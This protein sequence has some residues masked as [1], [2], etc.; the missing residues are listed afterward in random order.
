MRYRLS[1]TD[2]SLLSALVLSPAVVEDA[3]TRS[4]SA[5]QSKVTPPISASLTGTRANRRGNSSTSIQP[6]SSLFLRLFASVTLSIPSTPLVPREDRQDVQE[7][8]QECTHELSI[9]TETV[10]SV[11]RGAFRLTRSL[12]LSQRS[13]SISSSLSA[14]PSHSR[15]TRHQPDQEQCSPD[16]G[17]QM[18]KQ[19][20]V[21]NGEDPPGHWCGC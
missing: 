12:P 11:G 18:A 16:S 10:V 5:V 15:S 2:R 6:T 3:K 21:E 14:R 9:G 17:G 20:G 19:R 1:R 7:V 8:S 13:R 4:K